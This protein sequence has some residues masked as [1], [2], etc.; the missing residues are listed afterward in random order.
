MLFR[1]VRTYLLIDIDYIELELFNEPRLSGAYYRLVLKNGG[2]VV[3]LKISTPLNFPK[4]Q[5][6]ELDT[7][8]ESLTGLKIRGNLDKL[9]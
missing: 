6:R 8:I 2:R 9:A 1:S 4:E 7:R 5:F 3:L